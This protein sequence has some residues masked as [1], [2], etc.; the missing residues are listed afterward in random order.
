MK[1]L[2]DSIN[3]Q[4]HHI[5]FYF[6]LLFTRCLTGNIVEFVLSP[7]FSHKSSMFA[8]HIE[9]VPRYEIYDIEYSVLH[10]GKVVND[11][12]LRAQRLYDKS[13]HPERTLD[14]LVLFLCWS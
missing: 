5:L 13:G 11:R 8:C 2:L 10:E 14:V 12:I 6:L 1:E 9:P 4:L 3:R 7:N